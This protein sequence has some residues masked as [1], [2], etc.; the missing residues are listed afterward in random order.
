MVVRK[1]SS[2]MSRTWWIFSK[3][4]L[5]LS[6]RTWGEIEA[7]TEYDQYKENIS[8]RRLFVSSNRHLS[9]ALLCIQSFWQLQ[10]LLILLR[11]LIEKLS[12]DGMWVILKS[13]M[14]FSKLSSRHFSV[15]MLP[16]EEKKFKGWTPLPRNICC[17]S[18]N[19]RIFDCSM[20]ETHS[21][22]KF[23]MKTSK[24]A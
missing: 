1:V 7:S 22:F 9:A 5:R 21:S 17:F 15:S 11:E 20:R 19:G 3:V 16:S 18:F 8:S 14:I 12:F 6:P 24:W 23:S 2:L 4:N 13:F 10:I